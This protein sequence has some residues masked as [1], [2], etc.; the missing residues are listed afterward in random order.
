MQFFD[1]SLYPFGAS[2]HLFEGAFHLFLKIFADLIFN[3]LLQLLQLKKH[4]IFSFL[5]GSR[6]DNV[7]IDEHNLQYLVGVRVQDSIVEVLETTGAGFE[8][9]PLQVGKVEGALEPLRAEVA[10]ELIGLDIVLV[11][12]DCLFVKMANMNQRKPVGIK[13]D[14][15]FSTTS[16]TSA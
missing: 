9:V 2:F 13:E 8:R 16:N 1:T 3:F 5:I 7:R 11:G 15:T 14:I 12:H 6:N 10:F 4:S